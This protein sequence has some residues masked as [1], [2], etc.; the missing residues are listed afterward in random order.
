[1]KEGHLLTR[2]QEFLGQHC[3]PHR[4]SGDGVSEDGFVGWT[5]AQ[6]T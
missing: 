5:R 3:S 6:G 2:D 4:S 1:M